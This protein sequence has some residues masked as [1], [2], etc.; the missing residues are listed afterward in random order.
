[1]KENGGNYRKKTVDIQHAT[2]RDG[3][4]F[5]KYRTDIDC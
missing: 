2:V 3:F 1:M 5:I 4:F